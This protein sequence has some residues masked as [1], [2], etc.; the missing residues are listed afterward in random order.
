MSPEGND[1]IE[2][3]N[4]SVEAEG[5]LHNEREINSEIFAAYAEA[6]KGMTPIPDVVEVENVDELAQLVGMSPVVLEQHRVDN[7]GE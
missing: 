7:P 6:E 5:A 2:E 1:T 4:S 3:L